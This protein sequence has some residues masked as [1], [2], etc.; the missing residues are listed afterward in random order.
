MKKVRITDIH[1]SDKYYADRHRLTGKTFTLRD[2][3]SEPKDSIIYKGWKEVL[4]MKKNG[5]AMYFV[6]CKFE[7][8]KAE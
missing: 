5:D 4:C 1:T 2:D 8:V 7:A 6:A 3:V